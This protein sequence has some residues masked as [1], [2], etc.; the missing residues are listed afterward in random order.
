VPKGKGQKGLIHIS[1]RRNGAWAE[2][3]VRDTGTGIPA[4]I[5]SKVF[6]PFFTTKEVGK[7]SGQGLSIAHGVIVKKHGG[8]LSFETQCGAGTIFLIQLPLAEMEQK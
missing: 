3:R 7:G 6:D 2:I 1:T 8:R 4:A 5:Q